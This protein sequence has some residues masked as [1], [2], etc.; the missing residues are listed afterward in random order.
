MLT[1]IR[2]ILKGVILNVQLQS[3]P[4]KPVSQMQ[5]PPMPSVHVPWTLQI[6]QDRHRGPYRPGLQESQLGPSNSG[7]HAQVPL[8]PVVQSPLAHALHSP[9]QAAPYRPVAQTSQF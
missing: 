2:L 9:A 7:K 8:T 3:S 5:L 6:E 4:L 1:T